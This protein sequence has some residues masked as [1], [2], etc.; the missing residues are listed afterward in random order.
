MS[1]H[2]LCVLLCVDRSDLTI[3][4]MRWCWSAANSFE[5][6]S[7]PTPSSQRA[8]IAASMVA[9]MQR[10][11]QLSWDYRCVRLCT[12]M[13]LTTTTLVHTLDSARTWAVCIQGLSRTML[14]DLWNAILSEFPPPP[15]LPHAFAL[16]RHLHT[17]FIDKR[18]ENFV[19]REDIIAT[20][21]VRREG[22]SAWHGGRGVAVTDGSPCWR[23][24]QEYAETN[25]GIASVPMVVVGRPGIGK[26]SVTL[27]FAQRFA[28]EHGP[29][30]MKARLAEAAIDAETNGAPGAG[31][32]AGAGT[33]AGAGAGSA[34]STDGHGRRNHH[35][36]NRAPMMAPADAILV[37]VAISATPAASDL[38]E[39]LLHLSFATMDA[40]G[41]E[42]RLPDGDIQVRHATRLALQGTN[43]HSLT[44]FPLY[45]EHQGWL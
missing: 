12:N 42:G 19:G 16:Q 13:Q 17:A 35:H 29:K 38:R 15:P 34:G 39:M 7:A 32:G 24:L 3:P 45:P 41:M 37:A 21:E 14:E 20:L 5:R 18:S 2:S 6:P 30:P 1:Q 27:V 26:T 33:G 8:S 25:T 4:A 36:N 40:L 23:C 44:P 22:A 31:A 43:T 9:R 10:A 28:V 11:S